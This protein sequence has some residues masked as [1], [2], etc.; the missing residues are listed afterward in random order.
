MY[1]CD[2]SCF[3]R[4]CCRCWIGPTGPTGPEGPTGPI[5][6]SGP[7]GPTGPVSGLTNLVDG[8]SPG[9]VRGIHTLTGDDMGA[10]GPYAMAIGSE[11]G[12]SG[13]NAF[14]LGDQTNAIGA[15]SFAGGVHSTAEGVGSFAMGLSARASGEGSHAEGKSTQA[16]GPQTHAEGNATQA[17]GSNA[18]AEGF[19]TISSSESTHAEGLG[20]RATD[21]A[22]HAEGYYTVASGRSA[23][24]EGSSTTASTV[25]SHAEG[26]STTASAV[27]AHAEGIHTT[28]DALGSHAEGIGT[29]TQGYEYAHIMGRYGKADATYSWFLGNGLQLQP[30]LAAKIL[31]S[32]EAFI[33]QNWNSG[34]TGY[35]EMY[36]TESGQSI[37]PGYFVT[38]GAS[39]SKIRIWQDGDSYILGVTHMVPGFVAGS[40]ELHWQGKFLTDDWGSP[41]ME[42]VS[43]PDDLDEA[44]NVRIP[45]HTESRPMLNPQFDPT[46]DYVSRESR[47]EWVRVGILGQLLVRDDGTLTPGG[48]CLPDATGIA[49]AA[50][51]GYRVLKRDSPD[52]AIILFR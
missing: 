48:Y 5:G 7:T 39:G 31:T 43:V 23:H 50:P 9:S 37:L 20:T 4:P 26:S 34:R 17:T 15:S 18:H 16:A 12:A 42:D 11:T 19:V 45:A 24:A 21:M 2:G 49:T 22:A 25:A 6:D 28:A 36:E 29:T 10:I 35:A 41:R 8:G 52:R 1:D 46:L 44:G 32:G 47:P 40:G 51:F 14:A 30:N 13:D 33:Q 38:F 27:A 3:P